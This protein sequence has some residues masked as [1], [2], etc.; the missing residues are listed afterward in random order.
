MINSGDLIK[1]LKK[2]IQV[3]QDNKE[4][5]LSLA[6]NTI[7]KELFKWLA[8]TLK[9]NLCITTLDLENTNLSDAE[10][11][12]AVFE[13]L[14]TNSHLKILILVN[15]SV[16]RCIDGNLLSTVL[17]QNKSL[18]KL[19]LSRNHLGFQYVG[20]TCKIIA[21]AMSIN[22]TLT[23]LDLSYSVFSDEAEVTLA[24]AIKNNRSL[25]KLVLVHAFPNTR[26]KSLASSL[27][28]NRTLTHLNLGD[29]EIGSKNGLLY[30]EALAENKGLISLHL[31]NNNF[32]P[33]ACLAII[34]ALKY[35]TSLTQLNLKNNLYTGKIR[36]FFNY[37]EKRFYKGIVETLVENRSL[38]KFDLFGT[39]DKQK[40]LEK[41][42]EKNSPAYKLSERMSIA[43]AFL[44][45][46][47]TDKKTL[48]HS[49]DSLLPPPLVT[50][51]YYFVGCADQPYNDE[52]DK[53]PPL[54]PQ[55]QKK[56][57]VRI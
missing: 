14:L 49:N 20:D 26:A 7:S 31:W 3:P 12:N 53:Q 42:L 15:N 11:V 45:T 30:A 36:H 37:K 24:G 25:K 56:D 1:Y 19:D 51:V 35:N 44:L 13:V 41:F 43:R 47:D 32:A 46:Y 55:H 40:E 54:T 57:K 4:N 18:E 10:S 52:N 39:N 22:E 6:N 23:E 2:N 50:L 16:G 34:N 17:C 8:N 5:V 21:Q 48:T 38:F 29:N 33:N 9:Q 28:Q 27:K